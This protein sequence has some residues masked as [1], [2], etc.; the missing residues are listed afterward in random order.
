MKAEVLKIHWHDKQPI[1]SVDICPLDPR[2]LV[3]AGGDGK[4]RVA[5]SPDSIPNLIGLETSRYVY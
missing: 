1:Y 2:I 4:I 3:T 5:V